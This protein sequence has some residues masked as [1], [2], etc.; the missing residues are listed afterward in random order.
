MSEELKFP[1]SRS[2]THLDQLLP[3]LQVLREDD[4]SDPREA[5]SHRDAFEFAV[6]KPATG[7]ATIRPSSSRP[8]LSRQNSAE[9]IR[10]GGDAPRRN[11]PTVLLGAVKGHTPP[12]YGHGT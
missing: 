6:P 5:H 11:G 4:E 8:A 9:V 3:Q 1:R 7:R 10:P 2:G 12:V